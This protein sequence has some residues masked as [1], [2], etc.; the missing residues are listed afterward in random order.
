MAVLSA[1]HLVKRFGGLLATDDVSL[2]LEVGRIHALIGPNGAGKSTLIGQLSGEIAPDAGTIL[3]DGQDITH[4]AV[5]RRSLSGLIRSYQLTSILTEFTTIENVMLAV[6]ARQGHSFRFWRPVSEQRELR[7]PAVAALME[8]GLAEY[9]QVQAGMLAHGQQRQLELAMV[10]AGKPRV[11]LLDEPMAG[12]GQAESRQMTEVLR[13]LRERYAT[14][15]VEHDMEAVF[16]L[17]DNISVL[18]YG[19]CIAS[20][21]PNDIRSDPEVQKAYLGE[22]V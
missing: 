5:H 20:G 16:N 2:D 9:A 11:L 1:R 3:L 7:E 17:A 12:M 19:Q 8:A 13:R 14:L 22:P 6:Q 10:L 4:M 18:V 15:L 21:S